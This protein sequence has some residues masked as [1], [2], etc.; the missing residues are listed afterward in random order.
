SERHLAFALEREHRETPPLANPAAPRGLR[1]FAALALALLVLQI[2]LGGW[3]STSYAAL[4]CPD[5]PTC[6]GSFWP[7]TDVKTAFTLWHGLGI[8]YEYGILDARARVTIHHFHRVGAVIVT[9]TLLLLGNW[10]LLCG[11]REPRLR[12][13]GHAVL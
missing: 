12:T 3:T 9:V 1:P 7:E 6:H 11:R 2:F 13:L 8:N 10:L 5:L 4:A